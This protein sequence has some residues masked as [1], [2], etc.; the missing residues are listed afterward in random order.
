[1]FTTLSYSVSKYI[2]LHM[3]FKYLHKIKT[4]TQKK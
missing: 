4:N 2:P 3:D 1:M